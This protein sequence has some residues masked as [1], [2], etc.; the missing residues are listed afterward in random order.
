[1]RAIVGVVGRHAGWLTN[2]FVTGCGHWVCLL[3]TLRTCFTQHQQ[4]RSK[5]FLLSSVMI[6]EHH[7]QK[8]IPFSAFLIRLLR[9]SLF[10]SAL[11]LFSVGVG[12]LGYHQLCD[13]SWIDSLYMA[14]MILTGMGPVAEMNTTTAKVFSSGYALYSGV[15]F[16]SITAIFFAPVIHRVLHIL[17]VSE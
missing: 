15:A 9:F 14:C 1:M 4:G 17:H 3:V 6:F 16:L 12:V 10:A 2:N 11:I 8:V 13:L 5:P 7:K